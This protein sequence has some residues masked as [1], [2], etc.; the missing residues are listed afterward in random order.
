MTRSHSRNGGLSLR[1]IPRSTAALAALFSMIVAGCGS[2]P[3]RENE[4]SRPAR[5]AAGSFTNEGGKR[6]VTA[7]ELDQL[8]K[9]YA[10][11]YVALMA[12]ASDELKE[13]SETSRQRH[14]ALMLKLVGSSS[15]YDIA[16][17]PD[18]FTQ[19]VDLVLVVTLQSQSWIDDGRAEE[20]FGEHADV[21][22]KPLYEAREEIWELA[23]RVLKPLE[24]EYL[25][26][27]IWNWRQLHSNVG[28]VT[29]VRFDDFAESRGK[30]IVSD[31]GR[32]SGLFGS[33]DEVS[34]AIDEA[35][36][37]GE[38]LF[39]MSKRAPMLLS[40]QTQAMAG[41]LL[42]NP[43]IETTIESFAK[44]ADSMDRTS[45][46]VEELPNKL[47]EEREA[48]TRQL[49]ESTKEANSLLAE[50]RKAVTDT[51][52]LVQSAQSIADSSERIALQLEKTSDSLGETLGVVERITARP[53]GAPPPHPN[54]TEP[55]TFK[56]EDYAAAAAQ[57]E[58][59]A[60]KLNELV[61]SV[62]SLVASQAWQ[63]RLEEM[64]SAVA[65]RM[66]EFDTLLASRMTDAES[67]MSAMMRAGFFYALGLI[68]AF[69]LLAAG[70]KGLT[71]KMSGARTNGEGTS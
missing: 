55:E 4:G 53:E 50:Y 5:D 28:M 35:R 10:D 45:R 1:G 48:M 62:D 30:S 49:E 57:L 11:R 16:T 12:H 20:V 60:E 9:A 52:A 69:F 59:T 36:L 61:R 22:V 24:Q 13:L 56:I 67:S 39:F 18:P 21:L 26:N 15:I 25:D 46:V 17:N 43:D 38:R 47:S 68:A 27:L 44:V 42:R 2:A 7:R 63:A 31:A 3:P 32:R 29:L 65:T 64:D 37:M 51:N 14:E 71:L 34:R 40:W 33:V 66:A 58:K 19:L 6:Q 23:D 8:T 54:A 41:E 70:Y